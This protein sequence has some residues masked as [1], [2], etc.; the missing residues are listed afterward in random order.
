[1]I[2]GLE[3]PTARH[4]HRLRARPV[5]SGQVG[6]RAAP[7]RREVQIVFQDPY[8]SLDPRQTAEAAIDEVLR[9]HH[10]WP[11]ER[12]RARVAELADLVGLDDRQ[13]ARCPGRC[14]AASASGSRSPA[15][16]RPSRAC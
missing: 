13:S 1:M 11:A 15:R 9:L 12:R 7:A 2:V 6:P 8:S 4:D 14:P 16:W 5:P 10:G 3:R